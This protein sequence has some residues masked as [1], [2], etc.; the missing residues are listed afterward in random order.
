MPKKKTLGFQTTPKTFADETPALLPQTPEEFDAFCET[1][2]KKFS[3]PDTDQTRCSIGE[4]IC[5]MPK[6]MAHEKLSYFA[7]GVRRGIAHLVA[8]NKVEA[9]YAPIREAQKK[10]EA[11]ERAAKEAAA[12]ASLTLV[13]TGTHAV[14]GSEP[15]QNA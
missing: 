14:S 15:I 10:K 9:I 4:M 12:K 1:I 2:I 11:E 7:D 8:Y 3:L 6:T 13:E 5:H